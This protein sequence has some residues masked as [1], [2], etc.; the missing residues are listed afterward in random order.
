MN[1]RSAALLYP[2]RVTLAAPPAR[3]TD[4]FRPAPV[5]F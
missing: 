3:C 4:P 5:T 2:A 1:L